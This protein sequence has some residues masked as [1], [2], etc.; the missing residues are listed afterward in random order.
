M[1]RKYEPDLIDSF[2]ALRRKRV[3]TRPVFDVSRTSPSERVQVA[4][5]DVSGLR[6]RFF[7]FHFSSVTISKPKS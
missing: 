1:R 7:M 6:T 2:E 4:Y 3:K 5:N